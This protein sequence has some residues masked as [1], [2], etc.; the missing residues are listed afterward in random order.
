MHLSAGEVV[1]SQDS[2]QDALKIQMHG[3][4]SPDDPYIYCRIVP[5]P[6]IRDQ[7][8]MLYSDH[9]LGSFEIGLPVYVETTLKFHAMKP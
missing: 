2:S 6:L 8:L 4:M 7:F 9:F 3:K 1:A 5:S